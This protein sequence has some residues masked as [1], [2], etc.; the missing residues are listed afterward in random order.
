MPTLTTEDLLD[1][2][3]ATLPELGKGKWTDIVTDLQEYIALPNIL[4]KDRVV[5]KTGDEIKFNVL[6]A[7]AANA[8]NV[9]LY[10]EDNT[11]VSDGLEQAT[12]PW[13]HS[14]NS[15]A[16][17]R[18]EVTMNDSIDQQIVDILRER[19]TMMMLDLA[20]LME[21]NWFGKPATSADK[22]TPHG[23]YYWVV[24]ANTTVGGAFQGGRPSGFTD[25]AG[26]D[27]NVAKYTRWKNWGFSYTNISK[28]DFFR[29]LRKARTYCKF[30]SPT[31]QPNYSQGDKRQYLT[32]Y[33][34][35]GLAEEYLED[36]N[37]NLG[38]DLAAKDGQVTLGRRPLTWAPKLDADT[39]N[40]IYGINWGTWRITFLRG[41]YLREDA[42]KIKSGQH[43]VIE[44]FQ[45]C[46]YNFCC[47]DR[48]EQFVGYAA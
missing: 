6:V 44:G 7:R 31:P 35:I 38:N 15:W 11:N 33:A 21:N 47:Y 4:R 3:K 23:L 48:R 30:K 25:V 16:Y 22:D 32:N 2:T 29:K 39:T 17:D 24:K 42:P 46:T 43:N 19:K 28:E 20:E 27:P 9:G 5:F 8:R 1:L 41:E 37:D 18:R 26:L 10:E 36:R 14:V 13:R 34:V 40:P 45:D 12:L